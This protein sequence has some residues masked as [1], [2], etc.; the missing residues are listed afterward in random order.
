MAIVEVRIRTVRE[1]DLDRVIEIER[2]SFDQP[3]SDA[4]FHRMYRRSPE[5]FMVAEANGKVIGYAVMGEEATHLMDLAVDKEYRGQGI[6][7]A[8]VKAGLNRA[9]A[10]DAPHV[11][12]EVRMS[13]KPA[14][15]L[16]HKLGFRER[17]ILPNYYLDGEA[18]L[19]L[20]KDM[21]TRG[22]GWGRS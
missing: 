15:N 17:G 12:L 8:L 19:L 11:K 9:R 5:D 10:K 3:W 4:S 1:G 16:Y 2:E 18:A 21:K 22:H 13:N 6:G 7:E 20:V 14:K